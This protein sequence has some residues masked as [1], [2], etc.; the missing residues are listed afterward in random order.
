MQADSDAPGGLERVLLVDDEESIVRVMTR[1][2]E[3]LGFRATGCESAEEAL[4][5]LRQESGGGFDVVVT[6]LTMPEMTGLEL[7]QRIHEGWPRVR[8]ILC[9]GYGDG[10][11]PDLDTTPSG[12]HKILH[13]P[14]RVQHLVA[15]IREVVRDARSAET[16]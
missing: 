1:M 16:G 8:V 3:R 5:K 15:A 12:I 10:E 11:L 4:G 9:T 13:K 2:L 6:D 7:A 14:V